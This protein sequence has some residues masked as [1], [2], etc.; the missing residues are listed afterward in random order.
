MTK[1]T[2]YDIARE[3]NVSTAMVSRVINGSGPV[4]Q[5]K[6]EKILEIINKY[7]Y[8]P[9]ALAR[10]LFKKETKM[11]GIIL[12]DISNSFFLQIYQE[13]EKRALELGYNI[14]L[15]N[16]LSD[17][18]LESI[19]LKSLVEKQVDGIIFLGG[20]VNDCNLKHRYIEEM[21]EI[22]KKVPI[23]TINNIYDEASTINI[24]TDEEKGFKDLIKFIAEKG[25]KKVGMILGKKGISSTETKKEYF[26][27]YIGKFN[28]ETNDEWIIYS[29]FSINAGI[30]GAEKLLSSKTLPEVIMCIND[31]V[32]MGVIRRLHQVGLK[33]PDDIK[34]TGFDDIE[35]AKIFIPSLTTVSQNY[36]EIGKTVINAF[37]NRNELYSNNKIIVETK[38]ICRES[39]N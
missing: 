11:L 26:E 19:F 29:G 31:V 37:I 36:K 10:S 28:L 35:L 16:S 2:I 21:E 39:C 8:V 32:A 18:S 3:A 4:K 30:K 34:V 13:A 9:N 24:V 12:P 5:E 14:I 17:Y 6:R 1:V 20:R 15:C 33:V 23:V 27:K 38:L 7:G 25:Y 22:K